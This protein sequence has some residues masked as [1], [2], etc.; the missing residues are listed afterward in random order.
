MKHMW[1]E[2]EIQELISEQG[3]SGGSEVHLY[4]HHIYTKSQ[5]NSY[6]LFIIYSN[7][8]IPFTPDKI[9]QWLIDNNFTGTYIYYPAS[10]YFA[11]GDVIIGIGFSGQFFEM[12]TINVNDSNVLSTN[13]KNSTTI[14]ALSDEIIQIL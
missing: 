9:K 12:K 10:G 8:N 6:V 3:G 13:I 1:S 11:T 7:N 4:E 14:Y 2:E 5:G